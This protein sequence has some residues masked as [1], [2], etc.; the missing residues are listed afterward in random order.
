MKAV[1]IDTSVLLQAIAFANSDSG[2]LLSKG[3]SGD[4]KLILCE[5]VIEESQVVL[6]RKRPAL[7]SL[8]EAFLLRIQA[9]LIN[10]D[11]SIVARCSLAF[12]GDEVDSIVAAAAIQLNANH[13]CAFDRHF[14]TPAA[15][16]LLE[17]HKVYAVLP[18]NLV[19]DLAQTGSPSP[20]EGTIAIMVQ[21]EWT[22]DLDLGSK[23][24]Y[25]LDYQGVF[26]LYYEFPHRRFRL[27]AYGLGKGFS[28]SIRKA[29]LPGA[30]FF[31]ILRYAASK[32]FRVFI[33]DESEVVER[34]VGR[35]WAPLASQIWV[36]SDSSG[37]NQIDG[38]VTFKF[39]DNWLP[40]KTVHWMAQQH[41]LDISEA[42][43]DLG[44]MD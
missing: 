6:S 30:W 44:S 43:L 18:C 23:K 4:L 8:L 26:A 2:R 15:R 35:R 28:A 19:W 7:L 21:P 36:G 1:V 27:D 22:S 11:P 37:A 13:L 14:F 25:V 41:S 10:P 32:G 24:F 33:D 29:V 5:K 16:A 20:V 12:G 34:K 31:I 42:T 38:I 9:E 39:F 17:S 40:D 3:L